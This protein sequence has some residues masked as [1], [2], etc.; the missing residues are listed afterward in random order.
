MIFDKVKRGDTLERRFKKDGWDCF[1]RILVIYVN[2]SDR[3][4]VLEIFGNYEVW[5]EKKLLTSGFA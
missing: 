4:I 3:E 2:Y 5:S 1:Q